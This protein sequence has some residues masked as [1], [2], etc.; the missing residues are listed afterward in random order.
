MN[1][2]T[3]KNSAKGGIMSKDTG[4]FLLPK[5]IFQFS[6]LNYCIRYITKIKYLLLLIYCQLKGNKVM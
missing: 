1:I 4:G 5:Y 6:I 2:P 3:E